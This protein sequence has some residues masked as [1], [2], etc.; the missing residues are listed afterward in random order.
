M[1]SCNCREGRLVVIYWVILK[2]RDTDPSFGFDDTYY[3]LAKALRITPKKGH[4]LK[5]FSVAG[6]S[7]SDISSHSYFAVKK[8][9]LIARKHKG[10]VTCISLGKDR[11]QMPAVCDLHDGIP[12]NAIIDT[13][14]KLYDE[15]IT[16]AFDD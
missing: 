10:L 16:E 8:L 9:A 11:N 12:D 14:V 6:K 7:L 2:S 4:N 3:D 15:E 5:A 1:L 13:S